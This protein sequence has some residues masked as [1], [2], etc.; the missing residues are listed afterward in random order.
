MK[1][2]G[3][4]EWKLFKYQSISKP[5]KLYCLTTL[6][7]F[8]QNDDLVS[9]EEMI[10]IKLSDYFKVILIFNWTHEIMHFNLL[11]PSPHPPTEINTFKFGFLSFN[12]TI[13]G[14]KLVSSHPNCNLFCDILTKLYTK[15]V[16]KHG[17][18][19]GTLILAGSFL[20][21]AQLYHK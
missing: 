18:R 9:F 4:Y 10:E 14:S 15:W 12:L 11:T 2:N 7:T 5:S 1:W 3:I 20:H 13:C 19:S 21:W 6:I 16:H 17:S 8:S